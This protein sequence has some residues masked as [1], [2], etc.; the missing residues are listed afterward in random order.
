MIARA[1]LRFI[2]ISP[3]KA[4]DVVNLIRG[5]RVSEAQDILIALNK[6]IS[7]AIKDLL[8]SAIS[9]AKQANQDVDNIYISKIMVDAGPFLKRYRAE[10]FGKAGQIH[11]KLS[12]IEL[13]IDRISPK[14]EKTKS[15]SKE[16]KIKKSQA[17][18]QAKEKVKKQKIS[19]KTTKNKKKEK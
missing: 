17:K 18:L 5:K 8:N 13:E 6:K 15:T 4:R 9:N 1:K 19:K 2:R 7:R 12:H 16:K 11:R 14:K 10:S 3:K